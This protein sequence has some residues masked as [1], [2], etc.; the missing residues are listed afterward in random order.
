MS[1]GIVVLLA[2]NTISSTVASANSCVLSDCSVPSSSNCSRQLLDR[3]IGRKRSYLP[4]EQTGLNISES[5]H[6]LNLLND[7]PE[8][9]CI[10]LQTGQSYFF[11]PFVL[12]EELYCIELVCHSVYFRT[13]ALDYVLHIKNYSDMQSKLCIKH[14]AIQ[15]NAEYCSSPVGEKLRLTFFDNG[16]RLLMEDLSGKAPNGTSLMLQKTNRVDN[17][18]CECPNVGKMID[19]NKKCA[20][21][22]EIEALE[23]LRAKQRKNESSEGKLSRKQNRNHAS[24]WIIGFGFG[25]LVFLGIVGMGLKMK[26]LAHFSNVL[27]RRVQRTTVT[28]INVK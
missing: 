9:K 16:D 27:E 13:L 14:N 23:Q 7:S 22:E 12:F 11:V 6:L 2:F 21:I 10:D 17:T 20:T 25:C 18:K 3:F 8:R 28:F 24:N 26:L 19:K 15:I 5:D 4:P 1:V